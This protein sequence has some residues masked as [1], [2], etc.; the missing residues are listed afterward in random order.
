MADYADVSE[1]EE[2]EKRYVSYPP[3]REIAR[4]CCVLD[5]EIDNF[6]TID[7]DDAWAY[8]H[9]LKTMVE[10]QHRKTA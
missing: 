7:K 2:I 1:I 5:V 8:Y 9:E 3:V 6:R 10:H 4:M